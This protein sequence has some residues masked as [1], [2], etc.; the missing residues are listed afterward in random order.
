MQILENAEAIARY[1]NFA[2]LNCMAGMALEKLKAL[3]HPY[4][5]TSW[6]IEKWGYDP[7]QLHHILRMKDFI[8]RYCAGE[9]YRKILIPTDKNYLLKIKTTEILYSAEEA[10]RIAQEASDFIKVYKDEY[11]KSHSR[12]IN[13]EAEN[14]LYEVMT[15]LITQSIKSEVLKDV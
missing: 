15:K 7:K 4:P 1:D 12:E 6:K 13:I 3:S 2:S 10:Y 5:T 11:M 8:V 14:I 9:E